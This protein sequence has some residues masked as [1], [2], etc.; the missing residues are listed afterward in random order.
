MNTRQI[1]RLGPLV[2]PGEFQGVFARDRVPD[3]KKCLIFNTDPSTKPG[4][5]WVAIYDNLY[6]DS[7]G[8]KSPFS[9]H[10][11]VI[12]DPVQSPGSSCCGQHALYFLHQ[13]S[14]GLPLKYSSN[15]LRND[16]DVAKW[17]CKR[18]GFHSESFD[19]DYIMSQIATEFRSI[20][21]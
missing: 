5:H 18:F 12:F 2:C 11:Q 7:Y 8:Q 4:S 9:G 21:S 14:R 19:M 10:K 13:T 20:P 17:L 6:F 15:K 16:R 3:R 1:Q